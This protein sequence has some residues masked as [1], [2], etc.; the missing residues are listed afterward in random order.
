MP[1]IKLESIYASS[2]DVVVR[3]I[4]GETVIVPIT[5][6]VVDTEGAIFTLNETG[7]A[8]FNKL[9]GKRKLMAVINQLT[10]EYEVSFEKAR[11]N[12]VGLVEQLLEKKIIVE[13]G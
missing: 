8:I 13:K 2:E 7:K 1:K 3:D 12:T 11:D 9:D 5:S 10:E 4:H 6:S